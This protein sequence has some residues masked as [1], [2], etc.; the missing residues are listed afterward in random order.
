V[1]FTAFTSAASAVVGGG[2]VDRFGAVRVS[3]LYLLPLALAS[4]ILA[5]VP[6]PAGALLFFGLL[7]LTA[8]ASNVVI[9]AVLVEIFGA[10]QIGMIRAL[11]ASIMVIAS[12]IT[13]G[14]F[15]VVLDQGL[16][17][18]TIAF[19]CAAYLIGASLLNLLIPE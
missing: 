12:A 6:G 17:T 19:A 8:G 2:L 3:R 4:L 16:S 13:P 1:A 10:G 14:L 5:T 9:T 18:P 7:G 15:G 11:A